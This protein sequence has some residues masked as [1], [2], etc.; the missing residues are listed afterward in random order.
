[1]IHHVPETWR[2][3]E[4][5]RGWACCFSRLSELSRTRH[6]FPKMVLFGIS[7]Y[8]GQPP[9]MSFF[10]YSRSRSQFATFT[11]FRPNTCTFLLSA[12]LKYCCFFCLA[13]HAGLVTAF[14]ES[15]KIFWSGE[16]K[17]WCTSMN[18]SKHSSEPFQTAPATQNMVV[19]YGL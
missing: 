3:R 17:N 1:M 4:L 10:F 12:A 19:V 5:I 8:H 14:G 16:A 15:T 2:E 18:A 7:S 11:F 9:G 13:A 6:F